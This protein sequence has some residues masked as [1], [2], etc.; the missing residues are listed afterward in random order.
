M[1]PREWDLFVDWIYMAQDRG[2]LTV[3]NTVIERQDLGGFGMYLLS[4][5]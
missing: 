5:F 3:V 2:Q 1:D 4:D